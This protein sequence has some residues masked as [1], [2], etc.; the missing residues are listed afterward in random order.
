M[1]WR[2]FHGRMQLKKKEVVKCSTPPPPP[3]QA[4]S[5]RC[6]NKW[7]QVKAGGTREHHLVASRD[8]PATVNRPLYTLDFSKIKLQLFFLLL[9]FYADLRLQHSHSSSHL[10]FG[11]AEIHVVVNTAQQIRSLS[12]WVFAHCT[13]RCGDAHGKHVMKSHFQVTEKMCKRADRL[14]SKFKEIY[15]HTW[16]YRIYFNGLLRWNLLKANIQIFQMYICT[17]QRNTQKKKVI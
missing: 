9:F 3:K 6:L 16:I 11:K 12:H 17:V 14:K 2:H 8:R 10:I 4:G 5:E 13:V 15:I 7:E 1:A